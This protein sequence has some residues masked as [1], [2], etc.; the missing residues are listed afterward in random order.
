MQ[1]TSQTSDL[2][3][4]SCPHQARRRLKREDLPYQFMTVAAILL[5]LYSM[6]VF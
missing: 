2:S 6:W 4:S 3:A 5:L 1:Q